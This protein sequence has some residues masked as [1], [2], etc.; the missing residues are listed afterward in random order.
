MPYNSP[1]SRIIHRGKTREEYEQEGLVQPGIAFPS[2]SEQ[3]HLLIIRLD[4]AGNLFKNDFNEY[5]RRVKKG[6]KRLCTLFGNIHEGK[7]RID[8]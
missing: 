4:I 1:S 3:E 7:K 5:R 6:L 8:D 2:A